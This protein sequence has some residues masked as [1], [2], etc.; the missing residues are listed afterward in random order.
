M[1]KRGRKNPLKHYP[2][3]GQTSFLYIFAFFCFFI[4]VFIVVCWCWPILLLSYSFELSC[5][6]QSWVELSRVPFPHFLSR[7]LKKI[8]ESFVRIEWTLVGK[9]F[10]L[11][12]KSHPSFSI[13]YYVWY[14]NHKNLFLSFKRTIR[15]WIDIL[16]WNLSK[17]ILIK[18][19]LTQ[20]RK[21]EQGQ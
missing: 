7:R 6:E 16:V 12:I 11:I 2:T 1:I 21:R 4:V 3:Y 9:R 17:L 14:C 18:F 8:C 10:R 15:Q 13:L 20:K 5:I 19:R